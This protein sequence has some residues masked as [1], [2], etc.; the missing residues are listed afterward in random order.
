[1]V[2]VDSDVWSE[3][4]RKGGRK[5]RSVS[6]LTWLNYSPFVSPVCLLTS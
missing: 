6:P 5:K 4:F 2:P 3:A 1:M